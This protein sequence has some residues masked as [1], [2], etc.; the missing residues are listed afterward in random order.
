MY[1]LWLMAAAQQGV[2]AIKKYREKNAPVLPP[3]FIPPR[4]SDQPIPTPETSTYVYRPSTRSRRNLGIVFVVLLV[5]GI[6]GMAFSWSDIAV[7]ISWVTVGVG[8]MGAFICW[9]QYKHLSKLL[10]CV[11][12]DGLISQHPHPAY[13][14]LIARWVDIFEINILV[15]DNVNTKRLN[16][17]LWDRTKY[18]VICPAAGRKETSRL[19]NSHLTSEKFTKAEQLLRQWEIGIND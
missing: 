16:V 9:V 4:T 17:E 8:M 5:A 1:F 7:V 18:V 10:Y 13:P 19:I 3:H 2:N 6:S 14:T 11:G 15:I 12:P